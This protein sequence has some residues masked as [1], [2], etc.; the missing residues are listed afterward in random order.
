MSLKKPLATPHRTFWT[1]LRLATTLLVFGLLISFGV[2][3]CN[4]REETPP[5]TTSKPNT[6]AARA[7]NALPANVLRAELKSLNGNPIKLSAYS[8]KVL[9]VNLWAT[10][11]GPCRSEIPELVKLYKEFK[12]QGFEVVG[13]STENPDASREMVRDFVRAYDM[14]YAVG[15]IS[16]DVAVELMRDNSNIPQSFII[17]RDGRVAKRFIGFSGSRT[18]P[19]LRQAIE[20][21]LKT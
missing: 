1:P 9:L 7:A 3:S 15:W 14:N 5:A 10:W 17:T 2:A 13:L 11:C 4:S 19:Q 21:A 12:S 18:P 20:E 6:E 8:G 16:P